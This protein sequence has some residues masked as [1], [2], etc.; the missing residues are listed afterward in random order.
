M[1]W[2]L[3]SFIQACLSL[4]TKALDL[5]TTIFLD[6]FGIDFATIDDSGEAAG[7]FD[8]YFPLV[9]N[10]QTLIV[11]TAIGIIFAIFIFQLVKNFFGPL[12]DAEHP[13]SLLGRLIVSSILTWFSYDIIAYIQIPIDSVYDM[14][15][16]SDTD[17]TFH[18]AV[19]DF[20]LV[21]SQPLNFDLVVI[22]LLNL[23]FVIAIGWSFIRLL[24]EIVERYITLGVL[25]YT[26]PWAFA[27]TVSTNTKSVFSSWI[28]MMGSQYLLMF[29]NVFFLKVFVNAMNNAPDAYSDTWQ[30]FLWN[31]LILA[32][33]RVGQAVDRHMASLG[34]STA[35]TG[36]GIASTIGAVVMSLGYIGRDISRSHGRTISP[37]LGG[38]GNGKAMPMS[39]MQYKSPGGALTEL[40]AKAV[41]NQNGSQ[42]GAS[43]LTGVSAAKTT[44]D[45]FGIK[46]TG[47]ENWS[48]CTF[49][50]GQ[51][52]LEYMDGTAVDFRAADGSNA[53][54]PMPGVVAAATK[55]ADG[56]QYYMSGRGNPAALAANFGGGAVESY[57]SSKCTD[58]NGMSFERIKENGID[59]GSYLLHDDTNGKLY[60]FTPAAMYDT[61]GIN[62]R[63]ET[64]GG[65]E[66]NVSDVTSIDTNSFQKPVDFTASGQNAEL[67]NS[68]FPGSTE[69]LGSIQNAWYNNDTSSWSVYSNTGTYSIYDN[70]SYIS[71]DGA[72]PL[73]SSFG[74]GF[75]AV[76]NDVVPEHR[77]AGIVGL[78]NMQ[79]D[80]GSTLWQTTKFTGTDDIYKFTQGRKR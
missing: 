14:F 31:L 9:H 56:F 35:Q 43:V 11:A 70:L 63:T 44:M 23:V 26:A 30:F 69:S 2:I 7:I 18:F 51:A 8:K 74:Q 57:L 24:L 42:Q 66:W 45:Y 79:M 62:T 78:R 34:L 15:V 49:G 12:S 4:I 5:V 71:P 38:P 28:K 39:A 54:K 50:A 75:F 27:T 53:Q 48:K 21:S 22:P 76:N 52:H 20:N 13:V 61:T 47:Q 73:A 33:L 1:E 60:Q 37:D 17:T 10:M 46:P 25:F 58:N 67:F 36:N 3:D 29:L 80:E 6:N 72:T 77:Q 40:N 59:T 19:G 41:M 65:F 55:G 16:N 68:Y 32:F 64:Y